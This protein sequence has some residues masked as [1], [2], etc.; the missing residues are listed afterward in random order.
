MVLFIGALKDEKDIEE[1]DVILAE[2]MRVIEQRDQLV[3]RIDEQ[4]LREATEEADRLAK[5]ANPF[6]RG[7]QLNLGVISNKRII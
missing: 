2:M 5:I 4:R 7:H 3:T 1:E 6:A